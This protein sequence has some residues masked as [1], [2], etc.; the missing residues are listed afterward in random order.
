MTTTALFSRQIFIDAL[1]D[2]A[3][4]SYKGNFADGLAEARSL[5]RQLEN[6]D[7]GSILLVA[8]DKLGSGRVQQLW[9][10][11]EELEIREAAAAQD[12]RDYYAAQQVF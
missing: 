1:I 11:D 6:L 12:R 3:F 8:I 7:D 5:E 9:I 4:D 10:T 2:E